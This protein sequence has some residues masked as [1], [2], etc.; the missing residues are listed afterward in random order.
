MV[1]KEQIDAMDRAESRRAACH[2]DAKAFADAHARA[3]QY[4]YSGDENNDP[5]EDRKLAAGCDV[6]LMLAAR[7][8]RAVC[9]IDQQIEAMPGYAEYSDQRV[10]DLFGCE[11]N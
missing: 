2:E 4:A 1:T 11:S 10:K 5:V 8:R 3:R 7:A 6:L 9:T